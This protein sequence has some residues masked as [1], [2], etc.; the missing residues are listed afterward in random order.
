MVITAA[1]GCLRL[2]SAILWT[3]K[4]ANIVFFP[5]TNPRCGKRLLFENAL[6]QA[7]GWKCVCSESGENTKNSCGASHYPTVAASLKSANFPSQSSDGFRIRRLQLPLGMGQH[8]SRGY[9]EDPIDPVINW[10]KVTFT[11]TTRDMLAH[12]QWQL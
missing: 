7:C 1:R 9:G 10:R 8:S 11:R 4:H 12:S 6:K 5:P 2:F 3:K